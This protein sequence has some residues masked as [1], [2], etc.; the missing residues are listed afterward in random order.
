MPHHEIKQ[1]ETQEP[2]DRRRFDK[3]RFVSF[4]HRWGPH[5]DFAG[6][7]TALSM[8][9]VILWTGFNFVRDTQASNKEIIPIK[10]SIAL[11][12]ARQ[13]RSMENL[14][15]LMLKMK[16]EPAKKTPTEIILEHSTPLTF[17]DETEATDDN[18]AQ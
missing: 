10:S 14:E 2:R 4:W 13:D 12:I 15:R 17:V 1:S 11:V 18:S 6:G 8:L 3:C 5:L 7:L 16:V 9:S